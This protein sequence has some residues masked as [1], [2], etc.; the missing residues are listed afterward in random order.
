MSQ[1]AIVLSAQTLTANADTRSIVSAFRLPQP[2]A[3]KST[4]C[5]PHICVN[6]R[7][8]IPYERATAIGL[9]N[10]PELARH[11]LDSRPSPWD[12]R[13]SVI[14]DPAHDDAKDAKVAIDCDVV[15][16]QYRYL[17]F[18][19]IS[20]CYSTENSGERTNFSKTPSICPGFKRTSKLRLKST[21]LLSRRD[22][23]RCRRRR[24]ISS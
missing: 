5:S 14:V 16:S 4:N 2:R 11:R 1:E 8:T 12:K 20:C 24:S 17:P 19:N 9:S 18:T 13:M 6:R 23:S 3:S 21:H 15:F 22:T 10:Q 7:D